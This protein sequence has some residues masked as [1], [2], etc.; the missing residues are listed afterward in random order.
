[1]GHAQRTPKGPYTWDDF[2]A[3]PDDDRREL[4]DGEL[5]EVEVVPGQIHE[6][7][8]LLLG[9]Y[10]VRYAR[11]R[12]GRVLASGYKV[13]IGERR[14]VM[15]DIQY[16]APGNE[17]DESQEA[18]LSVGRPD[19]AVEILSPSSRRYDRIVK[20]GYYALIRVPEYWLIDPK[21]RVL[22]RLVYTKK[23]YAIS[24]TLEGDA[25]F[26]PKGFPGLKIPLGELW[27]PAGR[28]RSKSPK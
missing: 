19:V 7:I 11:Q 16:F 24:E 13:R 9:F 25:V 14:G 4:I 12:G 1:M 27:T 6:Y 20:L 2:I 26:A 28:K 5:V 10:L 17:P 8:V 15:P 22:E 23:G 18:G 21:N 3:L